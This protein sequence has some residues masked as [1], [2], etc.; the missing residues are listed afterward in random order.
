MAEMGKAAV[1]TAPPTSNPRRDT[2]ALSSFAILRLLVC[3]SVHCSDKRSTGS[4]RGTHSSRALRRGRV[5][6][7]KRSFDRFH[8]FFE[9]RLGGFAGRNRRRHLEGV[10]LAGCFE[11]LA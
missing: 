9:L 5:D 10:L 11:V 3:Q 1:T 8:P 2:R 4:H 6:A 7:S